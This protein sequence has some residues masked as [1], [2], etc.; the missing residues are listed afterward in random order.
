MG[1]ERVEFKTDVLNL[2]ARQGLLNIGA[3]PEG[4]LRSFNPMPGGRRRDA[5]YFSVIRAEWPETE[6]RLLG[7]AG[8]P[9][10]DH[11]AT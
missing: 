2:Q 6:Q 3:V 8:A 10:P 9:V 7:R 5:M 11:A 4:V 1:A